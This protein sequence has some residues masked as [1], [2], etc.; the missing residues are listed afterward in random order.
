M[1]ASINNG[2]SGSVEEKERSEKKSTHFQCS[3]M[4]EARRSPHKYLYGCMR[5]PYFRARAY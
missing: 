4:V 3:K 2:S 1:P 5:C